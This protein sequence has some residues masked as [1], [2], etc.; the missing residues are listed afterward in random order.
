MSEKD[1]VIKNGRATFTVEYQEFTLNCKISGNIDEQMEFDSF[2]ALVEKSTC[3]QLVNLDLG[4]ITS[5]NSV[6]IRSWFL[7]LEKL[8]GMKKYQF[9]AI[10]EL[11]ILLSNDLKNLLGKTGA[12]ILSF[13]T[14]YLCP[15]CGI[16][17]EKFTK[18][19]D[20]AKGDKISFPVEKCEQ[21]RGKLQFDFLE[22]EY[23]A[24]VKRA[25]AQ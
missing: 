5:I 19:A 1:V 22:E 23:V 13:A 7:F 9:S 24:F 14:Q 3:T 20:V 6:G 21:C 17:L 25:V 16:T 8:G 18:I 2:L 15:K 11:F 4:G 10:S 12:P